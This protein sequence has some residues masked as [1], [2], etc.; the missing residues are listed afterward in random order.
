MKVNIIKGTNQIG[1]C[2][3]EISTL[4]TKI[5]IDFGEDLIG[6]SD[7]KIEGLT[8]GKPSYDA[9]FITHS[10]LDHIGLIDNILEDIPV[11]VEE[12][13]KKIFE[14]LNN[15]TNKKSKHKTIDVKFESKIKIKDIDVTYFIVDHSSYNS[16]MILV[17]SNN[18]KI[19][20]TGDFRNHGYKG[21][22]LESTL[23]KIGKV[24]CLIT[25]GTSFSRKEV[26]YDSEFEISKKAYDIFKKYNQVFILQSSTNI[27]RIVSFYKAS[28][29]SNK[30][31]IEDLFTA[32]VTKMLGNKIPNPV[33]FNDVSV[34]IPLKYRRK[35]SIFKEK[36]I[37]PFKEYSKSSSVY[38]DYAMLIKTSM[39]DDLKLLNEKGKITNACLIYSMWDGYME[40][41]SFKEFIDEI[42]KLNIDFK[43]LHTS[44][45]ADIKTIERL[46]EITHPT[47]IIPIH[48]S[49]NYKI[50][51]I[52]KNYVLI[53]D[54]VEV[55]I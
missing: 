40:E 39:I 53:S 6:D 37:Y 48:T 29:K 50:K 27:D 41:S 54:N 7:V 16:S 4:N 46:I 47:K 42:K 14:L 28:K 45:H 51:D 12:K 30:F 36:Y 13:S 38:K 22:L 21:K 25:E 24:D 3:T 20:H 11:Y 9:V 34:W 1:G 17:E 43:I 5:I 49:N 19:L 55:E 26:V 2:I 18:K 32:N 44:G 10:H 23:N 8:Y 52:S 35:S 15:F 31:F 33:T